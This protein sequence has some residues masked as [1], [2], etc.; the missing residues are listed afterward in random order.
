MLLCGKWMF[1][2]DPL[3]TVGIPNALLQFFATNFPNELGVAFSKVGMIPD[4]SSTTNMPLGMAPT[5]PTNG[6][7]PATAFTCAS[8]HFSQL[9]DGRYAV[10]APHLQWDYAT[11]ILDLT[12]APGIAL[13]TSQASAHDPAAVAKVQPI[14]D[15]LSN[16]AGLKLSLM[17]TLLPLA[18]LKLP[19]MPTEEEHDY[20][21][22]Q[23]GTMDFLIEPLPVD[24][25][26]HIVGKMIGLWGIPRPAEVTST[27]MSSGLLAWSGD[28]TDL[29]SFLHG[30]A[31]LGGAATLPTDAEL[32][33]LAEYIYSLRA[34]SNPNPSNPSAVATGAALFQSAGCAT[35][36]DGPRGSGKRAYSFSEVGTDPALA[37]WADPTLS[38]T[39]CCGVT[40]P[41]DGMSHG[42]KSP[43]LV[44][45]WTLDR[46][47]HNGSLQSL[48]Q[49]LCDSG[50]D[51]GRPQDGGAAPEESVGHTFGCNLPSDQKQALIAFLLSH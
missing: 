39:A 34:P 21:T 24:D 9:S 19:A 51:A 23:P 22:W 13:G 40:Q 8:C 49:L 3:G 4:P 11:T 48:Q 44:G 25:Q 7:V 15:E 42:V 29:L 1:F 38:G 37:R 41:A 18:S 5:A 28:A 33:P 27:G 16:N 43:R 30:F 20:A 12:I 35:C 10:G 31:E 32:T 2:Y 6:T 50:D 14:L 26:V 17:T 46:F 36:H 45:M 47:L